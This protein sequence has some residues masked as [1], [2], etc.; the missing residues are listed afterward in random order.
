MV[1]R[2]LQM[3]R[4]LLIR[5]YVPAPAEEDDMSSP[6]HAIQFSEFEMI[7]RVLVRAGYRGTLAEVDISATSDAATFLL[8][9]FGNGVTSEDDLVALLNQRGRG[10][11]QADD[12]PVQ[13]RSQALDRW[14]DE[15]GNRP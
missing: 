2:E 7:N 10:L 14:E 9:K 6:D 15:G 1:I 3:V 4:A 11:E 8:E 12:T 5:N 13:I